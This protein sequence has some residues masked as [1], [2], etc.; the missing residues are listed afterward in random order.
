MFVILNLLILLFPLVSLSLLFKA[1][2]DGR[3]RTWLLGVAFSIFIVFMWSS[4]VGWMMRDTESMDV[5]LS[6][7]DDPG[8]GALHFFFS[9]MWPISVYLLMIAAGGYFANRNSMQRINRQ[10]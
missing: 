3:R 6:M 1:T 4:L 7:F 9:S 2:S 8:G 5:K 10:L